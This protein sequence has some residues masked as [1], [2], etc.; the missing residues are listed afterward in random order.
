[1]MAG[2]VYNPENS[3]GRRDRRSIVESLIAQAIRAK[4]PPVAILL[5][6]EKP[7]GATQF[8]KGKW[9]CLMWLLAGAIKGTP[10]AVD[11]S[12][13]GCLGGGTGLGF[14]NQ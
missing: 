14:G 3:P 12:S 11:E 10:A 2:S 13:F 6:D 5:S 9:G 8:A 7:E 1:M 4:L